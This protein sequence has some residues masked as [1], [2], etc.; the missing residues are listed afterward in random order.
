MRQG[1]L[2]IVEP[3]LSTGERMTVPDPLRPYVLA[4]SSRRIVVASNR[5]EHQ[6]G[7]PDHGAGPGNADLGGTSHAAQARG[8]SIAVEDLATWLAH[9][10]EGDD[11]DGPVPEYVGREFRSYLD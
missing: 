11:D 1:P 8:C 2:W 5:Q 3:P 10:R 7:Q 9:S 4:E 6:N